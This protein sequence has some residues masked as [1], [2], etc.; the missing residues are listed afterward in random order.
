MRHLAVIVLVPA[1]LAAGLWS[2]GSRSGP[3]GPGAGLAIP[4]SSGPLY[5]DPAGFDLGEVWEEPGLART[6]VIENREGATIRVIG[7]T[8]G[9]DRVEVTPSRFDLPPGQ[10]QTVRAV[11]D[12]GATA[13]GGMT[14]RPFRAALRVRYTAGSDQEHQQAIGEFRGTVK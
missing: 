5:T 6:L 14:P 9:C 2:G 4:S 1:A 11:I 7:V 8:C 3:R 12:A 13:S 10:S